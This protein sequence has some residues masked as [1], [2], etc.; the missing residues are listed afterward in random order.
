M[1]KD[2]F[3]WYRVFLGLC[4]S[5][6]SS[7]AAEYPSHLEPAAEKGAETSQRTTKLLLILPAGGG[8]M[9]VIID[10]AAALEADL[11]VPKLGEL[12]DRAAGVSS[13]AIAASALTQGVPT[14]YSAEELRA[15]T[16]PL[17]YK[18]FP[19]VN[20]LLAILKKDYDLTLLELNT[21]FKELIK[22]SGAA[23]SSQ[24]A[25]FS[26]LGEVLDR[27][28]SID[29]KLGGQ[30]GLIA[31]GLKHAAAM[32]AIKNTDLALALR[33]FLV[34]ILGDAPMLATS[35][36]K[37]IAL[38]SHTHEAV[39]FAHEPLIPLFRA[40]QA[41]VSTS[42]IDALIASCAIPGLVK[43]ISAL[44]MMPDGSEKTMR[45]QDGV[46]AGS[47]LNY[48]P[49][50]HFYELYSAIFPK[51]DLLMLYIGNGSK[52]DQDFRAGLGA[53]HDGLCKQSDK[54]RTISFMAIDA[55]IED[56]SGNDLFHLAQ[57]D[58]SVEIGTLLKNAAEKARASS[59]YKNALKVLQARGLERE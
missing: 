2:S 12:I 15:K 43:D 18:T 56:S 31:L 19:E 41:V 46:F 4:V 30:L 40:P 58:A 59:A 1:N 53:C 6:I 36:K 49:S 33:S 50:K 42:L 54:G 23:Q 17:V 55:V 32:R 9:Q 39:F 3:T 28:P 25:L 52:V 5:F 7:C 38:A 10:L 34:P 20:R 44:I 13:G 26:S 47:G 8:A 14:R 57:F 51:D 29:E 45:L 35:N 16:T 48:D 27:H 11:G 22:L 37:L 21:L 24:L